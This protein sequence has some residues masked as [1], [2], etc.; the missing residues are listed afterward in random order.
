MAINIKVQGF[1]KQ[2][3]GQICVTFQIK[4][5]A[6]V[7]THK[8]ALDA[9][10]KADLKHIKVKKEIRAYLRERQPKAAAGAVAMTIPAYSEPDLDLA[11]PGTF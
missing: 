1:H 6:T 10:K 7:Q 5:G 11:E 4:R 8:L 9:Y 3:N 2:D